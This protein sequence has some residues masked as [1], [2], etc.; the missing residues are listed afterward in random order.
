M[1]NRKTRH[2][3]CD[4]GTSTMDSRSTH[5]HTHTHTHTNT[6]THTHTRHTAPTQARKNT[7][8]RKPNTTTLL[9][10]HH[11]SL[12]HPHLVDLKKV[13]RDIAHQ[14]MCTCGLLCRG[15]M[16][17]EAWF[18]FH[19]VNGCGSALMGHCFVVS[20]KNM[21]VCG[22]HSQNFCSWSGVFFCP[23]P[24][25]KSRLSIV[26]LSLAQCRPCTLGATRRVFFSFSSSLTS[27]RSLLLFQV[28]S[29]SSA[30]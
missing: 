18:S 3:R 14:R 26:V 4:L 8:Q 12:I 19:R 13:F 29:D 16:T 2:T 25:G 1:S 10:P 6:H 24:A 28:G 21:Q 27:L 5:T 17:T 11:H 15:V 23:R 9:S 30:P 22:D 7:P 20:K